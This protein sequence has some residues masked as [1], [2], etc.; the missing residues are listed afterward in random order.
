MSLYWMFVE[1]SLIVDL[2]KIHFSWVLS[3]DVQM[4]IGFRASLQCA[5]LFHS[6]A[7][8]YLLNQTEKSHP[9][10]LVSLV[11]SLWLATVLVMELFQI[12]FADNPEIPHI[13]HR[14][15]LKEHVVYKEVQ[16]L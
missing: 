6:Y 4:I 10:C 13:R 9:L 8:I 3:Y 7:G 15:V 5:T 12:W 14:D 2:L 1:I 11:I 16:L